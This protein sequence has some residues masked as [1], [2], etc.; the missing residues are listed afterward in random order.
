M[1]KI[2]LIVFTCLVAMVA[3]AGVVASTSRAAKVQQLRAASAA[4]TAAEGETPVTPPEGIEPEMYKFVG[5]DTYVNSNKE[6]EVFVVRDGDDIYIQGLSINYL[7]TGWVK[8]TLAD[9][10]ATFPE[11]YMGAFDFWGDSYDLYFDGA[12]FA[13]DE[14]SNTFTSADGYTTTAEETVLDEYINVTLTGVQPTPATPAMPEITEFVQDKYGYYVSMIIPTTDVDGNDIFPALLSYQILYE[15]PGEIGVFAFTT[16]D[17]IFIEE[18]MT[19]VPYNYTDSYDI[20]KGGKQVYLYDDELTSWAAVGVKSIYTVGDVVNES[21]VFWFPSPFAATGVSEVNAVQEA[22][23][24]YID[25]QGREVKGEAKGLLIK[26]T[27]MTDG[28]IQAAKVVK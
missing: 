14:A 5:Y 13:Y 19:Q 25:L 16:D 11:A 8:G 3:Q 20:D 15:K 21:D 12:V 9:G 28:S 4:V 10:V 2:T 18:D 22:A 1:K 7:P 23:S 17:Y 24:H 26:V 27:Q 6:A